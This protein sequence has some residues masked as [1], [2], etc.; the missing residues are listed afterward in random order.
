MLCRRS[1]WL[2]TAS[3]RLRLSDDKMVLTMPTDSTPLPQD[4]DKAP[5]GKGVALDPRPKIGPQLILT[6]AIAALIASGGGLYWWS[7]TDP[8]NSADFTEPTA[9]GFLLCVVVWLGILGGRT[10][11]RRRLIKR[12]P[13]T[14]VFSFNRT[15]PVVTV[16]RQLKVLDQDSDFRV[17]SVQVVAD[18]HGM[19]LW[20]DNPPRM[21]A[22]LPWTL[23]R[24]VQINLD[25]YPSKWWSA[26]STNRPL[27]AVRID[28]ITSD[29]ATHLSLF[30]ADGS[31]LPFPSRGGAEW[32]ER[33]VSR[34]F[35][36]S[37][38]ISATNN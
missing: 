27:P 8:H 25:L 34:L 5:T 14:L 13:G 37:R 29:A 18:V 26:S 12:F 21:Y 4:R 32:V 11:D 1:D 6:F 19:T 9:I 35:E 15:D 7:H 23:V 33:Q 2:G 24:G 16:L 22:S 17:G 30:Y 20:Q 38:G 28:M 10:L 3:T 31:E 36:E